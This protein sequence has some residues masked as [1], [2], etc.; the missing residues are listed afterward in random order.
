[1]SPPNAETNA[2]LKHFLQTQI[3]FE[4]PIQEN[5]WM[6]LHNRLHAAYRLQR[7]CSKSSFSKLKPDKVYVAPINQKF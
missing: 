3:Y 7:C 4:Q 6:S 1:M 2:D 5:Y